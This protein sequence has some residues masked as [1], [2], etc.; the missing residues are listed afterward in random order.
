MQWHVE[1]Y[2]ISQ[3]VTGD[4]FKLPLVLNYV[5]IHYITSLSKKHVS[6]ERIIEKP[7]V[8]DSLNKLFH[9]IL[10]I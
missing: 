5:S 10:F 4:V 7:M 8:L 1:P 2:I 9:L 3:D 6:C